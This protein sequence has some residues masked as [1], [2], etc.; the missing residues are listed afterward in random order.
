MGGE[1]IMEMSLI[2]IIQKW[3]FLV[4][5]AAVLV[6][7]IW[8]DIVRQ[9]YREQN[10]V[11]QSQIEKIQLMIQHN[12]DCVAQKFYD[13]EIDCGVEDC[14]MEVVL[15]KDVYDNLR[16]GASHVNFIR[17]LMNET[18]YCDPNSA[19]CPQKD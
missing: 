10:L 4:V 12:D 8:N 13:C 15:L 6:V 11:L 19:C 9:S 3:F 2:K 16:S 5:V 14:D 7:A 18:E 1:N 17:F